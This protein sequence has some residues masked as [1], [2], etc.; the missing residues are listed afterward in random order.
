MRF[1]FAI[2]SPRQKRSNAASTCFL[3]N[4]CS[5]A[6]NESLQNICMLLIINIESFC[7]VVP[8]P[9]HQA[10]QHSEGALNDEEPLKAV[11]ASLVG[12]ILQP[13][14]QWASND[15]RDAESTQ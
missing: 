5:G 9:N 2:H 3:Q 8:H 10:P 13:P 14:G 11:Q 1:L 15:L 12:Q 6:D 7:G 4:S